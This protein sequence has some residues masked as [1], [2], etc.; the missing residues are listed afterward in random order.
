MPSVK[1]ITHPHMGSLSHAAFENERIYGLYKSWWFSVANGRACL[2]CGCFK[3]FCFACKW[4]VKWS[5]SQ[6]VLSDA[7]INICSDKTCINLHSY[8]HHSRSPPYSYFPPRCTY[9]KNEREQF[10]SVEQPQYFKM[11]PMW[12]EG[13]THTRTLTHTQMC[14]QDPLFPQC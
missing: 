3:L 12:R 14:T 1:K 10:S 13:R 5:L 7:L 2:A 4:M 9:S 11:D 6:L 8:P